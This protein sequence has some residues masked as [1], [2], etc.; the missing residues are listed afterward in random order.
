MANKIKS[1]KVDTKNPFKMAKQ[2]KELNSNIKELNKKVKEFKSVADDLKRDVDH[3]QKEISGI[4]DLVA[5]DIEDLQKRMKLPDVNAGEFSKKLFSKMF[6][7]KVASYK[8]YYDVAKE[9]I[10]PPNAKDDRTQALTP[11]KRGEGK[12]YRFPVTTGYPL[13]W[14]K[15]RIG[16]L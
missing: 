9:Y 14:L 1:F 11:R 12:N 10:P 15:K 16:F 2:L 3:Y 13:F 4:D 6:Y 8:K 5:K 7:D